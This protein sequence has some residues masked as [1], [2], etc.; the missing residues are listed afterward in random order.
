MIELFLVK[1]TYMMDIPVSTVTW[2]GQRYQAARKIEA[3]IFYNNSGSHHFQE[4]TEGDTLLFKW[5]GKELF[6]G[7]VFN[8]SR[9]KSGMLTLTAYDMLQYFLL[10][11]DVYNFSGKRLDEILV[12]M[13]KDFE[14][15]YVPF[16]NTKAKVGKVIDQETPLYDIALRAMID[17]HKASKRKF[18]IESRLG[19]VHLRELKTQDIQ[20]VLEVGNNIIDYT[21]DTSIEE[22]ATRVKLASGEGN[23]TVTAVV[24]DEEGKKK[25]GVLQHYEKVSETLKKSALT[26]KGRE[27]LDKKKG[28]KKKL[29]VEAL[30]IESATSGNAI[31]AMIDDIRTKQTMYIDTDVHTFEG[32]KHT[33]SLHLIETNDFPEMDELSALSESGS[34]EEGTRKADKVVALAKSYKGRLK[35]NYGGKNI[36]GGSGDCSG[37]TY[38]IFKKV[39]VDLGPST[40]TQIKKGRKVDQSAAQAGDLVFFKGTMKSRGPNVVS[41]VGIVTKPGYCVSL[42]NSGCKEHGYLRSNSSYWGPKFMQINRVL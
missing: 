13:C 41:H 18:H 29:D 8:R 17:T 6:R 25:F 38:F 39:G 33:M 16:A 28:V 36:D 23:K 3:S 1:P 15:P 42:G 32:N 21:Y 26:K 27:I 40:A 35:Y 34:S 10:N 9:N 37:F 2:S 22:T 4:V 19:K 14:V 24:T 20:W 30:G 5:K 7:T 12:R 31:Y 11:K